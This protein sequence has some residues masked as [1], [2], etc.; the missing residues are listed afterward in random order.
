MVQHNHS[1]RS[2]KCTSEI[3]RVVC[4]QKGFS[5]SETKASA[6]VSG[7]FEPMIL[8]QIGSELETAYFV[9]ISTDASNHKEIK[10]FPV[11]IRFFSS[12]EGI[13]TRLIEFTNLTEDD[14]EHIFNMLK[15]TWEKWGFGHKIHCYSAD[16]EA[17]NFGSVD[18]AHGNLNVFARMQRELNENLIGM[19]CLAHILHNAPQNACLAVFPFDV[20]NL[21]VLMYKQFYISTKQ[22]ER[23]KQLCE[24]LEIEFSKLKGCPRTRFLAKKNSI[25]SVLKVFGAVK[26]YFAT[27]TSKRMARVLTDFFANPL[28]KF[29]LIIARDICELFEEAIVMIEGNDICGYEAIKIV[30][31]LQIKLHGCVEQQ[32][33]SIEA[34]QEL[35][36]IAQQEREY[37]QAAIFVDIMQPIYGK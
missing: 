24:E 31:N 28:Q 27:S 20:Q 1:F 12:T 37:D 17:K 3:V 16:N 35:S 32:F 21:L 9:S 18:R 19:G 10:M 23:L 14:G 25:N 29:Y 6:I 34:E 5:C 15:K 11:I 8:A 36:K 13:K 4:D 22:T 26:E 30:Q 33:M 7:V 2:M